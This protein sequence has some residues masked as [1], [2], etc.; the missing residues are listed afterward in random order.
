VEVTC[1]SGKKKSKK[2]SKKEDNVKKPPVLRG[3]LM[4]L[5]RVS[6]LLF[7]SPLPA[8]SPLLSTTPLSYWTHFPYD[9]LSQPFVCLA[10]VTSHLKITNVSDTNFEQQIY[11][12]LAL[13]D[14]E[15]EEKKKE[16]VLANSIRTNNAQ[17]LSF[18]LSVG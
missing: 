6:L 14:K 10:K 15:R 17:K 7:P 13:N 3:T 16:T 8:P 11:L 9:W 5:F 2:S 4:M 12:S 1:V 18:L